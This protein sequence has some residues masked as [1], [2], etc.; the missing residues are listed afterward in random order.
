MTQQCGW[1][2]DKY[3]ISWQIVPAILGDLMKDPAR[4]PKVMHALLQMTKLDIKTLKEA[5]EQQ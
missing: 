4:T 5:Y 1:V 3:G 2:Q